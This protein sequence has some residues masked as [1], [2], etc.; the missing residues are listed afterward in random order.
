MQLSQLQSSDGEYIGLLEAMKDSTVAALP[1]VKPLLTANN[2][3]E[4]VGSDYI[5][6]HNVTY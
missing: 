3:D 1:G 5:I 6:D 2:A 4:V